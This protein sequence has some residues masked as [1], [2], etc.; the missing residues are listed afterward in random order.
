[1]RDI[2]LESAVL[3]IKDLPGGTKKVMLMY[4]SKGW[5]IRCY[6]EDGDKITTMVPDDTLDEFGD[7]TLTL[8]PAEQL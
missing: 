6:D 8:V 3:N 4:D 5:A 7:K 2:E 1:M